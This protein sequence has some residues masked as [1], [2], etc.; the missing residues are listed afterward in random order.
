MRN[1]TG[2]FER[3]ARAFG[4]NVTI[5]AVKNES[6]R[7]NRFLKIT[8]DLTAQNQAEDQRVQ[9]AHEQAASIS[10]E[11]AKEK[12]EAARKAKDWILRVLSHEL[13]TPLT[14]ILFFFVNLA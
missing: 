5:I 3:V 12:A 9:L 2:G 13:R 14:P 4:Q 6:G 11:V 10:A 7:P 8:R 1:G